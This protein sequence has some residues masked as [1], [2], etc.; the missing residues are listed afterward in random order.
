MS[1]NEVTNYIKTHYVSSSLSFPQTLVKN[2]VRKR[3][4]FMCYKHLPEA[5][6][7]VGFFF[8]RTTSDPIPVPS[9]SEEANSLLPKC[10]ETGSINSKPLNA[11]ERVL[12]HVYIPMLMAAGWFRLSFLIWATEPLDVM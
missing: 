11:L 7:T 8:S 2:K 10:F 6:S 3:Q 1:L 5:V 12:T 9:S 4:L